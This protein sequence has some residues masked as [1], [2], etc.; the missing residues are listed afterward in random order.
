MQVPSSLGILFVAIAVIFM[1]VAL[2]VYLTTGD[3]MTIA[4]KIWM[5]MPS[6][7]AAVIIGLFFVQIF[8]F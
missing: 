5:Q 8:S 1:G 4:R 3:R 2:R 6:V 7:F